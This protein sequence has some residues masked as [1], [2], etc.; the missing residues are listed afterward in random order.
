MTYP[1][2]GQSG[3]SGY[4]GQGGY[5][6]QPQRPAAMGQQPGFG[7]GPAG[8]GQP[9]P[10][11]VGGSHVTVK[12][13]VGWIPFLLVSLCGL[14]NLFLGFGNF[15]KSGLDGGSLAFYEAGYGWAPGALGAAGLLGLLVILPGAGD[16]KWGALI[17]LANVGAVLPVL[18]DLWDA[19]GSLGGGAV[20]LQ[21]V[22]IVQVLAAIVAYLFDIGV[23]KPPTAGGTTAAAQPVGWQSGPVGQPGSVGQAPPGG[24]AP[25]PPSGGFPQQPQSGA[26]G[27][28]QYGQH[29]GAQPGGFGGS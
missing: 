20:L 28:P 12:F 23:L 9:Q 10:N 11:T 29:P 2:G 18:F 26:F 24:F 27:Q 16:R 8:Y 7:A 3:Q 14:I 6:G 19:D 13:N 25:Q 5:P 22:A 15:L 4:P 17:M 1:S 21:I